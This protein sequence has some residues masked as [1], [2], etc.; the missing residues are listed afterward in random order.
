[1]LPSHPSTP[2]TI[3]KGEPWGEPAV[4]PSDLRVVSTDRELRDWVIWHRSRDQPIRDLGIAGGDLARTCGGD[5]G[6][7]PSAAKVTVDVMRITL[8]DGEPTWGVAHV[9]ARHW[10]LRGELVMVMNAEFYGK[11][12]VVPRSHP[13]DGKVDVVRVEPAMSWRERLQ[14]R[15]RARNG[16]HL[17]HRHLSS[18]SLADVDL[19]F[20]QQM[21][22]W[23]D[24]VR[25]GTAR[26]LRVNVEPDAFTAYV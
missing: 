16:S 14:A 24:G 18:R 8:D 20:G 21:V 22:V 19:T 26:R 6:P 25:L 11:Y 17:P 5:T 23:V 13:N 7:H 15:Q 3:R 1:M 9:V 2:M 10:W 12:D 4:C